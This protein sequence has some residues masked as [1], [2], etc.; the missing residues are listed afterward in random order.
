M[1]KDNKA[2]PKDVEKCPHYSNGWCAMFNGRCEDIK[3]C[4]FKKGK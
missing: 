2:K 1:Q 3:N 4:P